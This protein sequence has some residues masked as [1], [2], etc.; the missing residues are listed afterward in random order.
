MLF[1]QSQ[2]G[3][4][5]RST[6][7]TN[8]DVIRYTLRVDGRHVPLFSRHRSPVAEHSGAT[9]ATGWGY[10]LDFTLGRVDTQ[11]GGEYK[12]VV[13]VSLITR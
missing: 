11:S 7:P 5:L 3:G 10:S 2:N 1:A 13:T 6:D 9:T 4:V 12:D 8:T